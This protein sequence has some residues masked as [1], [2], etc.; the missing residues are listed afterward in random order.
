[1]ILLSRGLGMVGH[2]TQ[3][4]REQDELTSMSSSESEYVVGRALMV[5]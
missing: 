5:N 1:M 2:D 4:S 3:L